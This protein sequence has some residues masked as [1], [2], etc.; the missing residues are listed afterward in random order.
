MPHKKAFSFLIPSRFMSVTP[1]AT[2]AGSATIANA[3]LPSS[4]SLLVGA[5]LGL[6]F[7]LYALRVA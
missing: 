5:V 6:L 3:L 7:G 1:L 2:M 4:V